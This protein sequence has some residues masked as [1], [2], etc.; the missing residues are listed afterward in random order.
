MVYIPPIVCRQPGGGV[1]I[2]AGR[3]VILNGED[4]IS[5]AE[6]ARILGC[7]VSWVGSLCDRGTLVEGKDWHR[8]SKRG[9]YKIKRAAVLALR[10]LNLGE[11]EK[12]A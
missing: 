10:G 4:E 7:G 6:A 2:T 8:I 11:L 5:T 3:P 12:P 1:L 9:N